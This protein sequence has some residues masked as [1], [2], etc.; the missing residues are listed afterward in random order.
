VKT[1][2]YRAPVTAFGLPAHALLPKCDTFVNELFQFPGHAQGNRVFG[3]K[4]HFLVFPHPEDRSE[5]LFPGLNHEAPPFD[6]RVQL[7]STAWAGLS[8][9]METVLMMLLQSFQ[10][11]TILPRRCDS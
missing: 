6:F 5:E 4:I 1:V 10:M 11:T 3:L 7:Q 9:S 2:S 8:P